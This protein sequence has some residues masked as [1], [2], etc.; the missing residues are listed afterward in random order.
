[1]KKILFLL[2]FFFLFSY[3]AVNKFTLGIIVFIVYIGFA[4]LALKKE[5]TLD[6]IIDISLEYSKKSKVVL[7]I[8]MFVGA[9]T[10]SWLSSGTIPGL[11]ILE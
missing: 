9:L 3:V 2:M 10:A 8:F 4:L 5:N 7:M 1:M 6:S 11:Y